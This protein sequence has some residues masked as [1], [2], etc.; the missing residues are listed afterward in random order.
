M[1]HRGEES[2]QWLDRLYDAAVG[3]ADWGSFLEALCKATESTEAALLIV[4]PQ[5][6]RCTNCIRWDPGRGRVEQCTRHADD[7]GVCVSRRPEG[8]LADPPVPEHSHGCPLAASA[9]FGVTPLTPNLRITALWRQEERHG[10]LA[11]RTEG[12]RVP[13]S[14]RADP[15]DTI[16]PL[17]RKSLL[18]AYR[19]ANSERRNA[20]LTHA[21]ERSTKGVALVEP[22][23]R[24]VFASHAAREILSQQDGLFVDDGRLR[25]VRRSDDE[26][27]ERL[28]RRVL[29]T[30]PSSENASGGAIT[31]PRR[32]G[33][34]A[35]T[36]A[37]AP[38]PLSTTA[39]LAGAAATVFLTDPTA[40][41]PI[42]ESRVRQL[43]RL[44]PR[45]AQLAVLLANGTTLARAARAL[46]IAEKTARIHLQG[47]FRKTGTRRQ[48]DLIRLVLGSA[49][50]LDGMDLDAR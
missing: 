50:P 20:M 24:V 11:L 44:T 3:A 21:V 42:S 45:E 19:L 26:A 13:S 4:D 34:V 41:H 48:A 27:L 5:A 32:S 2:L 40:P 9:V 36:V 43:Y 47:L 7:D 25:A 46:G 22:G 39:L 49:E 1:A 33:R 16:L 37:A 15:L 10:Y 29:E 14:E 18:L 38:V 31:V 17:L 12:R 30:P 8:S 28:I 23:G 6:V 35:Y